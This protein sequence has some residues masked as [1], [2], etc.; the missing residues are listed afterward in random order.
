MCVLKQGPCLLSPDYAS[1]P[2]G[3]CASLEGQA[4][5]TGQMFW[6]QPPSSS[7][8][9]PHLQF[10]HRRA[11]STSSY[12]SYKKQHRALTDPFPSFLIICHGWCQRLDTRLDGPMICSAA[13]FL[14]SCVTLLFLFH[15]LCVCLL[16]SLVELEKEV[17]NIKTGLKA[18]EAVSIWRFPKCH[19]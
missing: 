6:G 11:G 9:N 8:E 10:D 4:Q 2:C 14:Y 17:N 13:E 1:W 3:V 7:Q 19:T 5:L 18:V 15:L 16:C 12:I